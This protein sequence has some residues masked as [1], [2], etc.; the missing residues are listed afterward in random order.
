MKFTPATVGTKT[1]TLTVVDA[2]GTQTVTLNG[3]GVTAAAAS[4]TPS[5]L[6]FGTAVVWS[7]SPAQAVTLSNTGGTALAITGISMGGV[8]PFVF[9][10]TNNCGTSLA[11][12]ASCTI[13]VTFQPNG[14][15]A[16][17]AVLN[18]VDAVGTQT[19]SLSGTGA[20]AATATVTPT[21]L[22][23]GTLAVWSISP[24]QAVTL[25][26]T[27][28]S[29]LAIT[30][31]SMGGTNP[32]VFTQTNNCGT[33]LAAGASCTINVTFQ[34]N[35]TGA[36]S[37]VLNVVDALGTQSVAL[38]G[39]GGTTT[40][41]ATA[42]LTPTSLA[43]GSLAVWSISPAQVVTLSNTGGS[44]LAITGISMGGVNPFVFTQTNNCGTSLAAGASCTINVTFQPNGTGAKS[45]V[46]NVVDAV[47][48]Q[49]VSLSGTGL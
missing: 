49:S 27:G 44:A 18:I 2:A 43:F 40:T 17:S 4:I 24:A 11:A 19:V 46:L 35:G 36:K 39:T 37:A 31:I 45:A 33:S 7:I 32:F 14:T 20:T 41:P 47:G 15:G 22:A 1:A 23:F 5:T 34:P 42:T 29:A 10:Q 12:G 26:N 38:S 21:S 48:T 30:G 6:A 9:T 8:N 3:T 13:N 28:G 16:K 25:S